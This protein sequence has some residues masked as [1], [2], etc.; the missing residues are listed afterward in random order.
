MTKLFSGD[1]TSTKP[2]TVAIE[3]D[4][5]DKDLVVLD[6]HVQAY[7]TVGNVADTVSAESYRFVNP[8]NVMLYNE[9][10]ALVA[11]SYQVQPP[12]RV[13]VLA[14]ESESIT[15]VN[16]NI[17]L[18]GWMASIWEKIKSVFKGISE[19]IKKFSGTYFTSLGRV[20]VG[21][22]NMQKVLEKTGKD[23]NGQDKD[24]QIPGSLLKAM[25]GKKD[26][27][28][29]SIEN[30]LTTSSTMLKGFIEI[31][32][33]SKDLT[34]TEF[35]SPTFVSDIKRLKEQALSASEAIKNNES[36]RDGPLGKFGANNKAI[37]A[38]N[39]KLTEI[40]RD[41]EASAADK[42]SVVEA[43]SDTDA[44]AYI[45]HSEAMGKF[46]LFAERVIKE[47]SPVLNEPLFGGKI[48]RSVSISQEA[49][50]EL[51]TEV[52]EEEPNVMTLGTRAALLKLISSSL[53]TIKTAEDSIKLFSDINEGVTK[54]LDTVDKL[55]SD[56]DK[57]DPERYGKFKN[58][59]TQ[60]LRTRLK[61]VQSFFSNY[62]KIGKNSLEI[63]MS[64][65]K[66]VL[67]YGALSLKYY[68]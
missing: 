29:V 44:G 33:M 8:G 23:Y 4:T 16:A 66:T 2:I 59:I 18:E 42:E 17:A 9:Y 28:S 47:L 32:K 54:S 61:L 52:S 48:L 55:V 67:E 30:S 15:T 20:K 43:V 60:N 24:V 22:E 5:F 46:T 10:I 7:C 26:I 63:V 31:G 12:K 25:A 56:I 3:V 64:G 6:N 41:A 36:N 50:L 53:E 40:Q 11:K 13:D 58:V 57:G 19:S 49:K 37:T 38:T 1:T 45:N 14:F 35:I 51:V 27:T 68:E 62:N 39:K 34:Q 21:L 65:G